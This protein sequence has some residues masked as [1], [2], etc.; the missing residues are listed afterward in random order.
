MP[1]VLKELT[2]VPKEPG[3]FPVLPKEEFPTSRCQCPF[4]TSPWEEEV[5]LLMSC[6][7]VTSAVGAE[8]ASFCPEGDSCRRP[9]HTAALMW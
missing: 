1:S 2:D 9:R 6:Y 7:K 3:H 5:N 8:I 4:N